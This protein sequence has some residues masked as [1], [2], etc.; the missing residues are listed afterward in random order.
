MDPYA[1]IFLHTDAS[2]YGI[3]AYLWQDVDGKEQAVA[4]ISKS[5]S[6]AQKRWHTPQK[7]AF[8]IFYS[9]TQLE[10]LLRNVEFTIKTDHKNLTYINDTMTSMVIRWNIALQ[11]F[12]FKVQHIPGKD[13]FVADQFSRLVPSIPYLQASKVEVD[14]YICQMT[15][16]AC[17]PPE[18]ARE[19][20]SRA[21]SA[22]T[23]HHRV[24]KK[25]QKKKSRL[26]AQKKIYQRYPTF[27][28]TTIT[29]SRNVHAAR[30]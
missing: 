3:G 24:E 17:T 4:F 30:R 12:N 2:D 19:I 21:Y 8:A 6:G 27:E 18:H 14:T 28:S 10:Y 9:V 13:N 26:D 1:K 11:Q 22:I 5:L 25:M 29:L 20:L 7:E 15:S 23:G 16:E